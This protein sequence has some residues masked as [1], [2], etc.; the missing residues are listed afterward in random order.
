MKLTTATE[1]FDGIQDFCACIGDEACYAIQLV[2]VAEDVMKRP[3][4]LITSLVRGI[5]AG[6][7]EFNPKDKTDPDN[8][9]VSDP[10]EF[11]RILTGMRMR[12]KKV[13]GN[14]YNPGVNEWVIDQWKDDSR[15]K[16]TYHFRSKNFDSLSN[17]MTV[18][19]GYIV[20]QRVVSLT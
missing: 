14:S 4:P 10:E 9:F 6:C 18:R 12:V 16:I 13:E 11:L 1:L 19:Y 20:S 15:G 8:F 7:I 17:S 2:S 5:Q 3:F